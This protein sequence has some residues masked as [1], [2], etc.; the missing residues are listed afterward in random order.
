[1]SNPTTRFFRCAVIEQGQDP[2]TVQDWPITV[3]DDKDKA[4]THAS[5]ALLAI[6]QYIQQ[7]P[8][9]KDQKQTCLQVFVSGPNDPTHANGMPMVCRSFDMV[10]N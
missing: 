6:K 1:M 2:N 9:I 10:L 8:A 4:L 7:H 3:G 5:A